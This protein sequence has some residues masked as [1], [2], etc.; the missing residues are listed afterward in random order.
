MIQARPERWG[1]NQMLYDFTMEVVAG[2]TNERKFC[3][4]KM[5]QILKFSSYEIVWIKIERWYC[6]VVKRFE[7]AA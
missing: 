4:H 5:W 6:F 3:F 2:S 7:F 1:E